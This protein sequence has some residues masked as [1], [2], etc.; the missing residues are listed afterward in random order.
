[1]TETTKPQSLEFTRVFDAP[2]E[3]VF[4]C[5]TDPEHL[6]HFWGPVGTSTPLATI[7][8]EPWAGGRFETV[9]VNDE[10]GEEYPSSAAC[11]SRSCRRR[12][13]CGSSPS[14]G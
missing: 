5:M 11:T 3:L 13:W 14:S 7:V 9:M 1:M 8:V 2:R 4:Q 6:T 12:S 10:N